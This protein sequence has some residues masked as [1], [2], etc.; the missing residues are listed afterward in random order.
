MAFE[1]PVNP[2]TALTSLAQWVCHKKKVPKSFRGK[3]GD[4]TNPA[5]WGTY[6]QCVTEAIQLNNTGSG[7]LDGIGFVFSDDDPFTGVDLDKVIDADG[8]VEPWAMEW[9]DKLDS[10]TEYSPS[11]L[12]FHIFIRA[13]LPTKG[14]NTNQIEVYSTERYFTFTGKPYKD[15]GDDPVIENRQKEIEWLLDKFRPG[16]RDEKGSN[17]SGDINIDTKTPLSAT[18]FAALISNNNKFKKTWEH[19]RTDFKD[20]SMS[21]YDLSLAMQA[22]NAGWSDGEVVALIIEHR[23][24]YGDEQNKAG[25][26]DY[27]ERTIRAAR[28][29]L[30]SKDSDVDAAMKATLESASEAE[31]EDILGDISSRLQL[32][33]PIT[34]I[35]KRGTD[36]AE[37]FFGFGDNQVLIGETD[38]L[39][40]PRFVKNKLFEHFGEVIPKKSQDEWDCL[41]SL[42]QKAMVY[43]AVGS[44]YSETMDAVIEY[45]DGQP[46]HCGEDWKEALVRTKPFEREGKTWININDLHAHVELVRCLP[47]GSRRKLKTR[48]IQCGFEGKVFTASIDGKKICKSYLGK[49]MNGPSPI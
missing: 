44:R 5:T 24:H 48:L 9:I 38:Q 33:N 4:S 10:Y 30:K 32:S 25:R 7:G 18:K 6:E 35:I 12:G 46:I 43:E 20:Q 16:W 17:Q 29:Y 49:T 47:S 28:D 3:A 37:Y 11:G 26:P 1:I 2:P 27:L 41:I 31:P 34:K 22:M 19:R 42:M 21:S 15:Y 13:K 23:S 45:L 40:S 8:K 36:P 39:F 14:K